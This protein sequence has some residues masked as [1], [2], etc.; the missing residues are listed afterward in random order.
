[1]SAIAGRISFTGEPA[2]PRQ[3]RH[4]T[5]A[6]AHRG[7]DGIR[8][9][10]RNS[11]QFGHCALWTTLE[12]RDEAQPWS[13]E[14]DQLTVVLDGH[15]DNAEDLRRTFA[16]AGK[17][18]R[19]R[20]DAELVL[21]AYELWGEDCA[22]RIIGEFAFV[23]WDG[24]ERKLFGAR[25]AVGTRYF[26][27]HWRNGTL[28]FASEIKALLA[29]EEIPSRLND[30]K[31]LDF[32][33]GQHDR[34]DV[35]GTFYEGISKLPAGH[36]MRVDARGVK[37]WRYWEPK[38]L[39]AEP[40]VSIDNCAEE[41]LEHLRVAVQCR[42]RCSGPVGA[43]LSGGL[44][45]SSIVGMTRKEFREVLAQPLSTFSLVG[46]TSANCPEW[47]AIQEMLRGGWISSKVVS[48]DAAAQA[49]P[50]FLG[51][52]AFND[53]P[54]ALI[55]CLP[56]LLALQQAR[57][58]GCR[59]VLEGMGGD[60]MSYS[61]D[62]S[63]RII[64]QKRMLSRIPELV[65]AQNRHGIGTGLG[66]TAWRFL[67]ESTPGP[68]RAFYRAIRDRRVPR[69]H[70]GA[71]VS[72][73]NFRRLRPAVGRRFLATK[74]LLAKAERQECVRDD[75]AFHARY[76]TSGL[77]SFA[78]EIEG[79]AAASIGVEERSPFSDRRLVEFAI[80]MPQQAKL[81]APWYKFMQRR[82]MNDVLPQAVAWRSDIGQHPG[83]KF[84][85]ILLSEIGKVSP[86]LLTGAAMQESLG[87]W[88]EPSSLR[89]LVV[90]YQQGRNPVT[91]YNLFCL[92]MLSQWLHTR[93]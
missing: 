4:M 37:T 46:E 33:V 24:R 27:Y 67:A 9:W 41:Y 81:C 7:P 44:D 74:K 62:S 89:R 87:A 19:N 59:V 79:D 14:S 21:R 31:V 29:L 40:F 93:F 84:H 1:M 6:M 35:V 54:F 32:L 51:G 13:C 75:Q 3:I 83:W 15:V 60:M 53:D 17:P 47:V 38:N 10:A 64:F 39:T 48:A 76:F 56:V 68:L 71:E 63:Q 43:L 91:G 34:D 88:V 11:V 18:P 23:I 92:A 85:D 28:C 82:A 70:F 49:C 58:S 8:H 66:R 36:A 55:H 45:S 25:D 57:Q 90:E 26:V 16:R 12:A 42:L 69:G 86:R 73:D 5:A 30:A 52:I 50:D 22:S 65:A 61:P 2:D 78:H 77:L 72:G 20:S 80:R